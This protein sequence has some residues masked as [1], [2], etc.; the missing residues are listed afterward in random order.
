MKTL[1]LLTNDDGYTSPGLRALWHV[2]DPEFETLVVAPAHQRSWIGKAITNPGPLKIKEIKIEDK[3]VYVV[4]D[5]TP[6][7]CANLGVYHLAPRKP[8]L[9]ISG[10]NIGANFTDSLTLSSGTVGAALEAALNGILGIAVS[11][12]LD[13]ETYR[14]L[15]ADHSDAYIES[16][17]IPARVVQ[18]FVRAVSARSLPADVKMISLIIP[19]A[20][21]EPLRFVECEPMPFEYG[22]V[23]IRQGNEY[24]NRSIAFRPDPA[25]L[26]PNSDVWAIQQGF[27]A[28][29]CYSAK[30]KRVQSQVISPKSPV[31]NL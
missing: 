20:I 5:G 12:D 27:V 28:Y 31:P 29:S 4:D 22:S 10:I 2:L 1:L 8:D 18:D 26:I 23:F 30:L 24:Y 19:R 15:H 9:V 14:A 6:A 13:T 7:D 16:F 3:P 11:L 21:A 17:R 25:M